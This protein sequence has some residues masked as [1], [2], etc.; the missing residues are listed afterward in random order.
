MSSTFNEELKK[1]DA[2]EHY[3]LLKVKPGSKVSERTRQILYR[4]NHIESDSSSSLAESTDSLNTKE[5]K[6]REMEHYNKLKLDLDKLSGNKRA[7]IGEWETSVQIL[8]FQV[9][10]SLVQFRNAFS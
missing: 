1:Q 5:A 4:P 6:Q 3:N 8:I 2:F 10:R 9:T 7:L